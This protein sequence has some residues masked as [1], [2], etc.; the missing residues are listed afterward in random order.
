M[1]LV[2]IAL[3]HPCPSPQAGASCFVLPLPLRSVRPP[4]LRAGGILAATR[5]AAGES[6]RLSCAGGVLG[7][8]RRAR[9]RASP[10]QLAAGRQRAAAW[11]AATRIR[12][13]G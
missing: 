4:V 9:C 3:M 5:A 10:S 7:R 11:Q 2:T 6:A 12:L 8:A 13:C 1:M